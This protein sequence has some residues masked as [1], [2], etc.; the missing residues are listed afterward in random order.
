MSGLPSVPPGAVGRQQQR[1]AIARAL[2]FRA[3]GASARRALEQSRRPKLRLQM[4]DEFRAIQRLGMTTLY[5]THDQSE[6]WRFPTASFVMDQGPDSA[7][8]RA[9]DI[10]ATRQSTV[11]GFFAPEPAQ[12]ECSFA[13]ASKVAGAA[14]VVGRGCVG[15][16]KRGEVRRAG[17]H[18]MVRPETSASAQVSDNG[19]LRWSEDRDTIFRGRDPSIFV[20]T[21]E[22][23]LTS[24]R[25]AVRCGYA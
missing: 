13:P 20:E 24:M 2:V 16:A 14:C 3:E 4:G 17:R 15:D 12:R 22:G 7:N 8:R 6:R 11:A 19:W 10:I 9:E 1:V 25:L 23:R 18:L 21:E 5:V